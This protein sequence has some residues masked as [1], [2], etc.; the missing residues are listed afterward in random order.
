MADYRIQM[1]WSELA[2]LTK[3]EADADG[4]LAVTERYYQFVYALRTTNCGILY[5]AYLLADHLLFRFRGK[6]NGDNHTI[7]VW[8]GRLCGAKDCDIH[9]LCTLDVEIGTQVARNSPT[10]YTLLADEITLSNNTTQWPTAAAVYQSG[11]D[12]E[13]MAMLKITPHGEDLIVFHA[14]TSLASNLKVDWT[15][16]N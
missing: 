12:T 2:T 14:H 8:S 1:P 10:N 7:D 5:P 9:R 15:G 13:L 4:A 3:T 11:N 16:Y 6:T